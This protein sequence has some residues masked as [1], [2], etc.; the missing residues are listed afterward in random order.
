MDMMLSKGKGRVGT[1]LR[2]LDLVFW[3]RVLSNTERR[4]DTRGICKGA[5]EHTFTRIYT[6]T[7]DQKMGF[8]Y[9]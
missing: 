5:R 4:G 7:H 6:H 8:L 3:S 1:I 9:A 2:L